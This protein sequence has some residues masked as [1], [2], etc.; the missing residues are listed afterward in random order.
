MARCAPGPSE[1]GARRLRPE[2]SHRDPR[3]CQ[4]VGGPRRGREGR[5]VEF[6]ERSLSLV[7]A[8]DQEEPPDL[9]I[10]RM[11]R[12]D[13]VAVRFERRPRRVERLRR[14][15]QLARDERDLGLGNDAPRA[16]HGLFRTE[17]TRSTSQE[18][19]GPNEIAEL[20]HRDAAKRESG[21]VVAQGDT[22][23][24]AKGVTSCERMSRGSD[25]RV[26]RNPATLVTP[27]VRCP[28]L[29]LSHDEWLAAR[30]ELL[31]QWRQELPWVR[32]DKDYRCET[33]EGSDPMAGLF[34]GRSQLLVYHF[35]FGPDYTKEHS[36]RPERPE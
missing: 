22:L 34:R 35:M 7:D 12:V 13:P 32:I 21:R 2:A 6:G 1:R 16:R 5:G 26:H 8:S 18:S 19:L 14:P 15:A 10:P 17:G 33:D 27:I 3:D 9:E 36:W 20:R 28:S 25:Q 30:L 31:A 23:Q 29:N 11:C 4:L 24:C